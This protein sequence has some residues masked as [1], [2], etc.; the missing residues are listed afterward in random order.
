MLRT[1]RKRAAVDDLYRNCRLGG[2]CPPDVKNKVEGTTLA[3]RLLQIFGSILYFGNLGI[4]TGKGSGGFGGYRP[5]GGT[6]GR[7][8]EITVTKPSIPLDPLGGAEVIPLDVINPEAPSVVPLQEGAIP[9]VPIT[10]TGTTTA[11]I[12][13]VEVTTSFGPTDTVHTS[14]TQPTIISHNTDVIT[15]D[16]QPGPPPPK[17]IAL[18]IGSATPYELHLNVF[19]QPSLDADI[20]VFVDPNITGDTVGL[21]EIELTPINERAEFSIEEGAEPLSSTPTQA[22][23]RVIN[24][25]QRLYNRFVQQV[26]TRNPDFIRQP[27]RLVT[28][29]FENPAFDDDV[30]Y[31]FQQDVLDLAAA[32]DPDFNDI[33]S[34]SRPL[35]S[36]TDEGLR[37]SRLGQKGSI[38]TR[39]GLKIGQKVHYFYDISKISDASEIELATF[40]VYSGEASTV[41][42]YANNTVVD[43][44][45]GGITY[46][47]S[48]LEDVFEE[49]FDN[50]H[51]VLDIDTE[52]G[53][54]LSVPVVP[55]PT[56][57]KVFVGDVGKNILIDF[58]LYNTET[59]IIRPSSSI[60][61][62]GPTSPVSFYSDDFYLHPSL[63]TKR[64]K[65]KYYNF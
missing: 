65:R 13:E 7:A 30:T 8:P 21:Q 33:I 11:D 63:F 2:D 37:I 18:D 50:S 45:L 39:S 52:N 54:A 41:N 32:P 25:G 3:D 35:Y 60:V 23:N 26:Q 14:N 15:V 57:V 62:L 34:L 42:A 36:K 29:E 44:N 9:N 40:G 31:T 58:P 12:A 16:M 5:I 53:K 56:A 1:R 59:T 19:Q 10:D 22:F 55:H 24:Q 48:A 17:R 38:T 43:T 51:L 4:G 20:N 6:T 47:E 49:T 27:S 28:F 61:P 46:P 64:K